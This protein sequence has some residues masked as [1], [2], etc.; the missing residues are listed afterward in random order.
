MSS[1]SS[2][3]PPRRSRTGGVRAPEQRFSNLRERDRLPRAWARQL[4]GSGDSHSV[5]LGWP[6]SAFL[7]SSG[8][9]CC[10][11]RSRGHTSR[12]LAQEVRGRDP[13]ME[14]SGDGTGLRSRVERGARAQAEGPARRWRGART[15][16]RGRRQGSGGGRLPAWAPRLVRPRGAGLKGEAAGG[17][18]AR[19]QRPGR[20][21]W[22]GGGS[23]A[24]CA[25][26]AA[27]RSLPGPPRAPWRPARPPPRPS[28]QPRLRAPLGFQSSAPHRGQRGQLESHAAGQRREEGWPLK[29][30]S[31]ASRLTRSPPLKRFLCPSR[32]SLELRAPSHTLPTPRPLARV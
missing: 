9:C 26:G 24:S 12:T 10:C 8:G 15:R 31:R 18:D 29:L 7:T 2:V 5:G 11:C 19:I 28:G 14:R 6:K 3:Y 4:A 13:G 16:A 32:L 20:P 27:G 17:S 23:R 30:P 25:Q 22:H 21:G 1:G